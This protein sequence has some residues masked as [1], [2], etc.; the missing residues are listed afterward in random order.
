MVDEN[1][2]ELE[3]YRLTDHALTEMKCRGLSVALLENVLFVP[4]Q[5]FVDQPG[6][7]VYQSRW[8]EA[9]T[10]KVDLIRVFVDGA[11]TIP[12]VGTAYRTSRV[13]KYWRASHAGDLF[14]TDRYGNDCTQ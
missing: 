12:E 1:C 2:P 9:E 8:T 13:Q 11:R 3:T 14:C 6:R 4:E 10:Q 5:R 7:C